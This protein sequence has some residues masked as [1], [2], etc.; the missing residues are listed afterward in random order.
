MRSAKQDPTKYWAAEPDSQSFAGN[1][2]ERL[3]RYTEWLK[4]TGRSARMTRSWNAFYGYAPDATGDTSKV[5]Q[6]G[7]Q[8]E[9]VDVTTNDYATLV[10]QTAGLTTSNKPGFK[11]I[12]SN[13]DYDSMAQA[14]FAQGLLE[15]YDKLHSIGDA[16]YEATL[17]GLLAAEGW[18]IFSWDAAAGKSLT[19]FS[20]GPATHEGD[21]RVAVATPFDVAYDVDAQSV[22]SLQWLAF[23]RRVNRFD[24]AETFGGPRDEAQQTPAQQN[25]RQ[26]LT[27]LGTDAKNGWGDD[28][29]DIMSR[30]GTRRGV[31]PDMVWVWEF[32]HLPTPSLPNGRLVKFVTDEC[33]LF[34]S[35]ETA[36]DETGLARTVDHGYPYEE[37]HAYRLSPESVIGS[38]AG[39]TAHFDL[40]SLQ[41]CL[42]TIAT[43]MA[44]ATN[45]GGITNMWT[46]TGDG[47]SVTQMAGAMNSLQSRV[48]PEVIE[49]VQ[50]SA[51]VPAFGEFIERR[52]MRRVGQSDVSMGEVPKGMPGNLAALLEAKTVQYH[53]RLQASYAR[54]LERSRTGMLKMLKRFANSPRVAVI[55]GKANTWAFRSWSAKDIEG[56]D[57][58][59]V[60]SISPMMSTQAG[61]EEAAKELLDHGLIQNAQ[62]YLT[63]RA[64]GRMEPMY[65]A[66]ETNMM[67]LRKEK[68]LLQQGVGL[69]PVDM[70]RS[71]ATGAPIFVAGEAGDKFLRPLIS[72]THWLDIP[73]YLAVLAMPDARD[74]QKVS[75]AVLEVVQEKL[76]LWKA[77]DPLLQRLRGCPENLIQG[78]V[79][80]PQDDQAKSDST[81]PTGTPS[82]EKQTLPSSPGLPSGSPKIPAARPPENPITGEQ[83]PSPII[84]N[85]VPPS[86]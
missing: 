21:I 80:M 37:L 13:A 68:E 55:A 43:Q 86:A 82:N 75:K 12:G 40:L 46:P 19:D 5:R 24:L 1:L 62:Q 69:P 58:F 73:E 11:A 70:A 23:R 81:P 77:C 17:V 83:S 51:Q 28:G 35:I 56:F 14:Q 79:Q 41:E 30:N 34:D 71:L 26:Q 49:G 85:G 53:S 18:E 4:E 78:L 76:R 72:D 25:I 60:E 63:L 44:T 20:D 84:Q 54:M 48:K 57:R 66:D 61:R 47:V 52:M 16:D 45:A 6:S 3:R 10:Q 64:T 2:K 8:G 42:D 59:M 67:R 15:Y 32:R 65:E 27:R 36:A 22:D 50:L 33:V 39:H 38:V 7:E 9:Y 74:N 29:F 31:A